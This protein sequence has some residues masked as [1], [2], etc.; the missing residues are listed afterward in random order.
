M[1]TT[2]VLVKTSNLSQSH[3]FF[4]GLAALKISTL[5]VSTLRSHIAEVKGTLRNPFRMTNSPAK[6]SEK[7]MESFS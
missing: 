6:Y 1:I 5:T 2:V 7:S 3:H 4:P